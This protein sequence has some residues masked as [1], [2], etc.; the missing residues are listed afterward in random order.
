MKHLFCNE[1]HLTEQI[2]K[3]IAE[4]VLGVENLSL[5]N[6]R[7]EQM[8]NGYDYSYEQWQE[9]FTDDLKPFCGYTDTTGV[10]MPIKQELFRRPF[11][12]TGVGSIGLDLPTW[13]SVNE[14]NPRIMLIFQDPLR[15]KCYQ[16]CK[17]AVLSSPFSLHDASHRNRANGGK[18][19]NELVKYLISKGIGVYLT[20]A[21]KYF[22]GDTK[23]R[24]GFSLL[25]ADNYAEIL[26]KEIE[27]VKPTLCVCLGNRAGRVMYDVATANPELLISYIVLPHLSGTARGAIIKRFP[28]LK[29][30]GAT[31][32]NIAEMYAKHILAEIEYL[33]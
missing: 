28:V 3:L 21:Y 33:K 24:A 30:L 26:E 32:N 1:C 13:F 7:Y 23:I 17:D 18:M 10:T 31:A 15:G 11:E 27:I 12:R 20:D 19:V 25:F 9:L 22:V 2:P 29:D 6:T 8:K 16:D 14:H 5:L 4:E